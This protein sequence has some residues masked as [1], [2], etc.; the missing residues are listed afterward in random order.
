MTAAA[1]QNFGAP[2]NARLAADR[3]RYAQELATNPRLREK[4]MRIMVNEQGS[5]PQGV[6]SIVE[7]AMN[8]A[9]VRGT[10]LERQLRW[11]RAERNGYYQ[12]GHAGTES[13]QYRRHL[14]MLNQAINNAL[15]GS[16]ISQYATDN[17]S[18]DLASHER[19][20][21]KFRYRSDY[22][23]E[24]FFAPGWGEPQFARR[25]NRWA[26]QMETVPEIA[27]R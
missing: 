17:S 21:G 23:G 11:H 19:E 6:Q 4:L 18:G 24:T 27:F 22:S 7:S 12:V 2:M 15:A 3:Q 26:Q 20:S 16:N 1:K 5:S 10:S 25:W 9:S 8:R 14:E 13:A